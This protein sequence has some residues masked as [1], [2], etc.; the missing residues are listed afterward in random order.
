MANSGLEVHDSGLP[1]R[2][3]SREFP[4][5]EALRASGNHYSNGATHNHVF[6]AHERRELEPRQTRGYPLWLLF[7]VALSTAVVVGAAVG[8][9]LGSQLKA[10]RW[11][12]RQ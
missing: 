5:H 9:G 3:L 6:G 8:G 11:Y 10:H 12:E 1:E 2:D 4:Q 7:V